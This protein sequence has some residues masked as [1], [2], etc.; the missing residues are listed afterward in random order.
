MDIAQVEA[1]ANRLL[2]AWN[3]QDVEKVVATY[4]DDV[5][6]IDPNTRGAVEGSDGMRRYLTKL[7]DRWQMHW[8]LREAFPLKDEDG[9]AILWHASFK[10]T[11]G[12][13]TVEADGM[14][15]VVMEGDRI[16]RNEVYFDRA[17]LAPL[18]SAQ[19]A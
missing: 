5:T 19:A 10:A 9:A 12:D 3:S 18:L 1:A 11:D 4:T 2:S 8:E 6:Y 17:I 14:D 7:F 13:E 16:K 15:L